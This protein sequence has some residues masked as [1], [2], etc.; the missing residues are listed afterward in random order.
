MESNREVDDSAEESSR[1]VKVSFRRKKSKHASALST[2]SA[3]EKG[4]YKHSPRRSWWDTED[5][6]RLAGNIGGEA[7]GRGALLCRW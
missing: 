1:Q 5:E 3:A 7:S 2:V 6:K 4:V